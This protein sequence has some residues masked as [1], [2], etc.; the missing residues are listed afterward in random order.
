MTNW[1]SI[2]NFLG[3][4]LILIVFIAFSA[5]FITSISGFSYRFSSLIIQ[6]LAGGFIGGITNKV[7][8]RMLFEKSWYL[9]GSGVLLKKHRE[10]IESLATTVEDH[11][12][13]T[14]MLQEELRKLL[15][16]LRIEKVEKILNYVIEE[17]RDD[18]RQFLR[19]EKT[20][21]EI[22][23]TLKTRLG[24]LGKFLN[25]TRI[26]EYEAMS[27]AIV[28]EL[29]ARL[30]DFRVS[31]LMIA[32]MI[33]RIGTLEDFLFRPKNDLLMKHYQ[34]DKSVAELLFQKVNIRKMV[35]DKLSEYKPAEI[36]DI[37]ENNIR[38]HLLWLEVFGVFLGM[39]FAG[40]VR[41][42]QITL[43]S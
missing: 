14:Q 36:R 31:R 30:A 11:L 3:R 39:L 27:D 4:Y 43:Q 42:L 32:M 19:T 35:T 12:I 24:F 33:E 22:T 1:N 6:V 13:N 34:T 18:I 9:P 2:I 21:N 7:A 41:V 5:A 40:A 29:D 28:S 20:R 25:I 8:I 37:I 23:K 16:P 10:I 38:A 15:A 26:K 17:F